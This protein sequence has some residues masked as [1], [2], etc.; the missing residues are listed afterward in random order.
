VA[1]ERY[2][3]IALPA[4]LATQSGSEVLRAGI[5]DGDLQIVLKRCFDEPADWGAAAAEILQYAAKIYGE[6]TEL[7]AEEALGRMVEMF[8]KMIMKPVGGEAT[9]INEN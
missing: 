2:D 9:A 8:M 4:E 7:A 3:Q 6:E 5:V 1:Q